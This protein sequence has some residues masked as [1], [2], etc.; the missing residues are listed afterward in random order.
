VSGRPVT[1]VPTDLPPPVEDFLTWLVVEKGRAGSTIEAYRRD[2]HV[3]LAYL[4]PMRVEDVTPGTVDGF[5]AH[6]RS[7]GRRDSTVKRAVVAVRAMHR[8]LADEGVTADDP[9][10]RTRPPRAPA[11]LPK[12]LPEEDVATLL[13]SIP[14]DEPVARRDRLILELLYGGGLRISEVVGLSMGDL[15]ME[16][17]MVRVLGKGSKE[18]V[19]PMGEHAMRAMAD[20]LS[21]GGRDAMAPPTWRRRADAD[22]LL[23]NQRGGRLTRQGAWL[24]LKGRAAHVGLGEVVHPHVLRHSCATHMVEHGADLR[25]VQELLGHASL[26]TTQIYTRVT[27]ERLRSMYDAAHPRARG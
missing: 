15:L 26:T 3:Y 10:R 1:P 17:A 14:G 22:A 6:L 2:L 12:A 8:H 11:S 25:A 21:P 7:A 23:L 5:I 9:G 19:V 24:V 27:V 20:W 4:G 16:D 18:R 13:D